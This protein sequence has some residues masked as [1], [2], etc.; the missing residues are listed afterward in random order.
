MP[1]LQNQALFSGAIMHAADFVDAVPFAGKNVVVVGAGNTAIDVCQDL[2]T[3]GVRSVTM[4]QRSHSAVV[5]RESVRE[6]ML[7]T[8]LPGILVSVADF[9]FAATPMGF[10]KEVMMGNQ[11]QQW[12]RERVLHDKLRKGG[13]KLALGLEGEGQFLLVFERASGE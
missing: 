5:D 7:R 3:G 13:V 9:K 2:A 12:A 11:E 4:V 6:D 8:F 1:T 10:M